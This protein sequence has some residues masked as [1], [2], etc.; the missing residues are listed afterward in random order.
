M[1]VKCP[2][3]GNIVSSD[4]KFCDK[5]GVP[6]DDTFEYVTGKE[7]NSIAEANVYSDRT[8]K[9]P[10]SKSMIKFGIIFA[11]YL[12]IIPF[13]IG[14]AYGI[15]SAIMPSV[16]PP[17]SELN[18]AQYILANMIL[19]EISNLIIIAI[20]IGVSI[21]NERIKEIF[22]PRKATKGKM[23]LNTI[24]QGAITFGF[25]LAATYIIGI[26]SLIFPASDEANANQALIETFIHSYPVMAFISVS[27]MA[28][29]VEELVFRFLLCKPIEQKH[30]WLGIIISGIVFGAIHL[31]A[32]AQE[33]TLIQDL[34]S[35]VSYVGMGLVFGYRYKMT[36]NVA[37]NMLAHSIHNTISFIV[38]LFV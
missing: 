12:L 28:P 1:N 34:P 15:A 25:M 5:C 2:Y 17:V 21:K 31:V 20:V 26:I 32:S 24:V 11:L 6:V 10:L 35:L 23:L 4:F 30:P 27:I 8:I 19:G 29:I 13:I 7:F 22:G 37:S 36:D 33:G 18:D 14:F 9:E 38:I 3:C 16:V